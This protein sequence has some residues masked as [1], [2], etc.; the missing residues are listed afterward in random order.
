MLNARASLKRRKTCG[1]CYFR[2]VFPVLN[3]RAS[4]KL[5]AFGLVV[6]MLSLFPVLN[7]RAS[8]KRAH[9]AGKRH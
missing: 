3:A 9:H 2:V 1:A 4:L 5:I 7:A 6:R 8:L